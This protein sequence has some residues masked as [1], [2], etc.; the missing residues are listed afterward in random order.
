MSA[1]FAFSEYDVV[2]LSNVGSLKKGHLNELD[3]FLKGGGGLILGLG[4][5]IDLKSYNQNIMEKFFGTKIS[6]F[7]S[8]EMGF[9]TLGMIDF[10]HPVFRVYKDE[11]E[12]PL[13]K[14]FSYFDF[15]ED[16]GQKVL[17]RL[18]N[19]KPIFLEKEY[20]LGKIL[21]FLSSFDSEGNDMVLHTFFVPF[22]HRCVEHLSRSRLSLGFQKDFLVGEEVE[23]ELFHSL[24]G[25][26]LK[27]VDPE[28]KEFFLKPTYLKE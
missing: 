9:S 19:Q 3:A 24:F 5:G 2:V 13:I 8:S 12:V 7:V 6:R 26:K 1:N 15:P 14:F 18:K 11:K 27:L 10:D 22:V 20:G 21:L 23:R 25:K 4:G 16:K 28:R 17:A